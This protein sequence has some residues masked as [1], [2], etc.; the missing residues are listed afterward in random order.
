MGTRLC[1]K[2]EKEKM[3]QTE[4]KKRLQALMSWPENQVCADCPERQPRWA[5]LIVPPPGSPPGSLPIGALICLECSGS[6]RRLGTHISFVRSVNLDSWKLKEVLAMENGGNKIVNSIFE[7]IPPPNK[8]TTMADGRTRERYIRDKYE[9]R[10]YFDSNMLQKFYNGEIAASVDPTNGDKKSKTSNK[11]SKST[12]RAPSEAAKKRAESRKLKSSLASISNKIDEN[13]KVQKPTVTKPAEQPVVAD[14]LD[15]S[16]AFETAPMANP[17]PPPDPPS[18]A[19]SPNLDLFKS[20]GSS[21]LYKDSNIVPN[22]DVISD[23]AAQSANIMNNNESKNGRKTFN[24]DEILSLFNQPQ[25]QSIPQMNFPGVSGSHTN[26]MMGMNQTMMGMNPNMTNMN[27]T[28]M[29]MNSN[30]MNMNPNM[31]GS[32]NNMTGMMPHQSANMKM[33][34]FNAQQQ[35][36]QQRNMMMMMQ[37]NAMIQQQQQNFQNSNRNGMNQGGSL[38]NQGAMGNMQQH[39]AMMNNMQMGN[40]GMMMQGGSAASQGRSRNDQNHSNMGIM[41][42]SAPAHNPSMRGFGM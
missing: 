26:N 18:L 6:H 7:A 10:K 35:Q 14:L 41:G 11:H 28:M 21:S 32:N 38:T 8:P 31:M 17:G 15:F 4:F 20:A 33:S 23:R 16:A 30:M 3:S 37:N 24:N 1:I 39:L 22:S 25:Q 29:G 36:A 2:G 13:K 27:Q 19:P 5:S 34:S 42:G 40:P 12:S 9:R